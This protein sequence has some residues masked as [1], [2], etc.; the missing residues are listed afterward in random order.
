M[1]GAI[2]CSGRTRNVTANPCPTTL[3]HAGAAANS[4]T[5]SDT[6]VVSKQLISNG[7]SASV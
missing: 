5:V 7:N 3:A 6:E 4:W 1:A 2:D